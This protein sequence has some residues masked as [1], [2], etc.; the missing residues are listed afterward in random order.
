[1][2]DFKKKE[3]VFLSE[4]SIEDVKAGIKGAIGR[5]IFF[6]EKVGSTN[7]VAAELAEK[8]VSEGT[9]VLAEYQ[10]KGKGRLGRR[11]VSP[12]G[13][14]IYMSIIVRP[15][16]NP[17]DGQ[18]ITMM[19][20]I[21][22]STAL[23]KLT[24]LDVTVKWPNDLMVSGRKIGGILTEMKISPRRVIYAIVGIG[25][26]VNIDKSAFPSDIKERATSVKNERGLS[27]PRNAIIVEILNEISQW[28]RTLKEKGKE[29]LLSEWKRLTSTLGREVKVTVG[30]EVFKGLAESIDDEGRLILRLPSGA[31]KRIRAGDITILR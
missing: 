27:Y 23:R 16:V 25:I 1:M 8:G 28:Y 13:V 17:R 20:A 14:N 3:R 30:K 2:T 9:V 29:I 22:C 31:V 26:N 24:S 18:F 4:I 11:W 15:E 6:Y 10:E 7:T 12:P 21:A 5:E 19:A